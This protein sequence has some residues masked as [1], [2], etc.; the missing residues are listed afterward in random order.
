MM[1]ARDMQITTEEQLET[2]FSVW[3]EPSLYNEDRDI[4]TGTWP[5]R[6][7]VSNQ[8]VKYGCEFCGTST[9]Q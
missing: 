1:A 6:L 4:N 8:T 2:V 5:S 7:G 9:Q 3:Y